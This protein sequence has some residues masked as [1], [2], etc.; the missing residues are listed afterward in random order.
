MRITSFERPLLIGLGG[1]LPA[2]WFISAKGL[3]AMIP[4]LWV[5][6]ALLVFFVGVYSLLGKRYEAGHDAGDRDVLFRY[7][8]WTTATA[9][10]IAA[11]AVLGALML[12]V[13]LS[14]L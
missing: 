13:R 7:N 9:V 4:S 1:L 10:V 6:G 11:A 14:G 5:L 3:M 8:L 2:L 12:G